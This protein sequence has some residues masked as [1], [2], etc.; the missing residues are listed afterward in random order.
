MLCFVVLKSR[1]SR[2]NG[3]VSWKANG[4]RSCALCRR[5]KIRCNRETP[6]SNCIRSKNVH[7]CVYQVHPPP[8]PSLLPQRPRP[9]AAS[10]DTPKD[11]QV[12]RA[13]DLIPPGPVVRSV[14]ISRSTPNDPGSF[15][16]VPP[17]PTPSAS[18]P[19]TA[20]SGRSSKASSCAD[21]SSST[22]SPAPGPQ[23]T[24]LVS[25]SSDPDVLRKRIRELEEQLSRAASSRYSNPETPSSPTTTHE[26]SLAGTFMTRRADSSSR[27]VN[28]FH[29]SRL[30]GQSHWVNGV[31]LVGGVPCLTS[32]SHVVPLQTL[33]DHKAKHSCWIFS[34]RSSPWFA[35]ALQPS[36]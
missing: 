35:T 15:V 6:C 27:I 26:C 19:S 32:L 24:A 18:G 9:L 4:S 33:V 36:P 22:H 30:F 14:P 25:N 2:D 7:G 31:I 3:D 34:R 1:L 12:S 29:K 28:V 5:R 13:P 23:F 10:I 16:I 11:V 8:Q 21:V 20:V 17:F